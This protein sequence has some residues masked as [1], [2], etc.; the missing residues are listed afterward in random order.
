[1]KPIAC[2]AALLSLLTIGCAEQQAQRAVQ[3]S[4]TSLAA[5]V[6]AVD[7]IAAPRAQS[8]AEE[9]RAQTLAE[10]AGIERYDQIMEAW[11]ELVTGLRAARHA[12][13]AA[14]AALDAWVHGAGLLADP[15]IFCGDLETA[16]GALGGLLEAVGIELPAAYTSAVGY[17]DVACVAVTRYI[18]PEE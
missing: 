5:G 8:A 12:L 10:G 2:L 16:V 15:A 9:A 4:L 13:Y 7:E 3:A 18:A 11:E 17:V 6:A 14:Q 1:M